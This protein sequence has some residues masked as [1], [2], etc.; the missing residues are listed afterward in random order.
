[1]ANKHKT[2]L[3]SDL[4]Y[5]IKEDLKEQSDV[6]TLASSNPRCLALL[7]IHAWFIQTTPICICLGI[8]DID[9][10]NIFEDFCKSKLFAI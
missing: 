8:P 5:F 3:L 2:L 6:K 4:S 9:F 7:S 10:Y 1:M